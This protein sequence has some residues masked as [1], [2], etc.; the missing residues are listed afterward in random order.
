MEGD[1]ADHYTNASKYARV[2]PWKMIAISLTKDSSLATAQHRLY[3]IALYKLLHASGYGASTA[4]SQM[5]A[6]CSIGSIL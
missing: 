5:L 2:H 4:T 6:G 1:D 3:N